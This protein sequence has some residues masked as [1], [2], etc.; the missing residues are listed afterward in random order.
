MRQD[1]GFSIIELMVVMSIMAILSAIAVPG[2]LEWLPKQRIGSAARDVKS[3]L[4]FARSNAIRNN[5]DVTVNFDWNN[6]RLTV[7]DDDAV[8]LRTLELSGDVDLQKGGMTSDVV[9]FNGH[10]F[11]T[12]TFGGMA[13]V[14]AS[15]NTFRRTVML[16][17]GGNTRIQ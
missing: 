15:N 7:A 12:G 9:T 13:V 14:N 2:I 6:D 5:A 10:G 3:T 11:S 17:P 4:E 16:T 8:T 1:T